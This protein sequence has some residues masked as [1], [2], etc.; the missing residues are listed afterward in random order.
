MTGSD[1]PH[2]RRPP[3]REDLVAQ[4]GFLESE[5]ADLR[6]RL[7][8]APR[9]ARYL[10]QR[11]AETQSALAS[12]TAQNERLAA[13]LREA[14][15]QIMTLKEEVDRL[16]QPPTGF[17]MF[18]NRNEDDTIDVFTGGRKLRVN[19]SPAVDAAELQRGQ[20]VMLNE[21][22]NVVSALEFET[23]GE[24]VM[25]KEILADG[26][27][28]L[29]IGNAD[30]ERVVRIAEPLRRQDAARGRLAAARPTRQLR[31]RAHPEDR[32]RGARPR[33][34]PGHRLRQHRRADAP[35]RPD[36][37]RRRAAV[38]APR[39]VQGAQAAAAEGRAALRPARLRQD[40]D[41]QGRR[42]LAGQ[43]G[44]REDRRARASPTSSTSRARSCST[45]TSARPSGTSGWSSSGPARRP[46]RA[47]R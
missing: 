8:D 19:V 16:A 40:A 13:T 33:R 18:L 22:L 26:E 11:L 28:A 15:D 7:S 29:V 32:G 30:E 45:S 36:P 23:V 27:R 47:P 5:V 31:L 17:G 12:L 35:D 10:E 1:D 3:A 21:A 41:R 20:E 38:P 2:R 37:R 39:A 42:E 6:R 44:R 25:L 14:R 9:S 43:A 24:V 46:T 4:V 34:G